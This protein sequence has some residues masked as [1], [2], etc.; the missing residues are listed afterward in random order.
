MFV[1]V[2]FNN[3]V[4]SGVGVQ[5]RVNFTSYK[6][7]AAIVLQLTT[8]QFQGERSMLSF[9]L[10]FDREQVSLSGT[11]WPR[12]PPSREPRT[13]P[14]RLHFSRLFTEAELLA[15]Q[16]WLADSD[17]SKPLT[18]SGDVRQ[19]SRVT[20]PDPTTTYL[21]VEFSFDQ[22]PD[23]WDWPISFPLRAHLEIRAGEFAYLTKALSREQW[24]TN[25]TW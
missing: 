5:E 15:I 19:I 17:V 24:S 6:D 23:W 18:L 14:L 22:V 4:N 7:T 2:I 11:L 9:A 10:H 21:D 13:Q 1:E 3:K 25:L 16:H 12:R 8:M 20:G